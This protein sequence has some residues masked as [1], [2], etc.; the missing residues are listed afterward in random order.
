MNPAALP[1]TVIF[2]AKALFAGR[3]RKMQPV[4]SAE[5]VALPLRY[6][7]GWSVF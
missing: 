1:G 5:T 2:H 6:G 3:S 4:V 7:Y